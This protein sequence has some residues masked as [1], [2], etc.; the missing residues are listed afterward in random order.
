MAFFLGSDYTGGGVPGF[1]PRRAL[2]ALTGCAQLSNAA[3]LTTLV[4]WR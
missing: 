3:V 2:R 1:G 4:Q